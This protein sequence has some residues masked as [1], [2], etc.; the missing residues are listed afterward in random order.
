MKKE[1]N[2]LRQQ[3]QIEM[4]EEEKKKEENKIEKE[5]EV[6]QEHHQKC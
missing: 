1:M 4:Y 2:I 3:N 5:L 6:I